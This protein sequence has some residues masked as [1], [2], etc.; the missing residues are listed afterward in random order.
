[1]N[2][3]EPN[4]FKTI[5]HFMINILKLIMRRLYILYQDSIFI[6]YYKTIIVMTS[7]LINN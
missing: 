4:E 7:L 6:I 1:M 5:I 2:R 3:I